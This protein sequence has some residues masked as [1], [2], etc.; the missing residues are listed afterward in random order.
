VPENY[1][2]HY[3]SY[4]NEGTLGKSTLKNYALVKK[5]WNVL[6]S[7]TTAE[8]EHLHKNYHF[9]ATFKKHS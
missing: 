2:E 3:R 5:N 4:A 8:V 9:R 1:W 6:P 7:R